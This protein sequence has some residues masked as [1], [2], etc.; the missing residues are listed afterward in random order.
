MKMEVTLSKI[1]SY[2]EKL[3]LEEFENAVIQCGAF[4]DEDG[5]GYYATKSKMTNIQV[6]PSHCA[7][8]LDQKWSH[9]IWF[10]K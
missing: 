4:N 6:L 5:C 1:P 10:N 7:K 2:G 3:T 8:K 9:I